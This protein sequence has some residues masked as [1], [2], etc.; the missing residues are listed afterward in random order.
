MPDVSRVMD[1]MDEMLG[2][3]VALWLG[4]LAAARKCLSPIAD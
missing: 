4:L 2:A 1:A 3:L